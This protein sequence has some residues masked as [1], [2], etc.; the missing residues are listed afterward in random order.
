[1]NKYPY[2]ARNFVNGKPYVVF[3]IEEETGVVVVNETDS[4]NIFLGKYGF[5][6]EE[7]FEMLPS[8]EFV[9]LNN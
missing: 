2:L 3:F 7:A 8:N 6:D 4:E 9:R 1:M 5:F